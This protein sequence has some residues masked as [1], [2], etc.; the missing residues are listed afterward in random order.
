MHTY[1]HIYIY[2]Y[3]H[4]YTIDIHRVDAHFAAARPDEAREEGEVPLHHRVADVA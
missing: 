2:T 4:T 1:I 3:I